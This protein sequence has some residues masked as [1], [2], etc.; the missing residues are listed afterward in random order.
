MLIGRRCGKR[1]TAGSANDTPDDKARCRA[2]GADGIVVG[3]GRRLCGAIICVVVEAGVETEVGLWL[4]VG[5]GRARTVKG[6]ELA[7]GRWRSIVVAVVHGEV[8]RSVRIRH[9]AVVVGL[10]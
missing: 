6:P 1:N 5:T 8:V 10:G 9:E 3:V 4:C 7:R 2:R